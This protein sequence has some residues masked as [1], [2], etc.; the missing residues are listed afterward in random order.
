MLKSVW[1]SCVP[2]MH[3]TSSCSEPGSQWHGYSALGRSVRPEA[4]VD[5]DVVDLDARAVDGVDLVAQAV[6]ARERR[7]ADLG[8]R[9]SGISFTF[10][11][12]FTP[13]QSGWPQPEELAVD[14]A[15]H[16]AQTRPS[17]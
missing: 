6:A 1:H 13:W 9:N 14:E 8:T 5:L 17:P 10:D 12:S 15:A 2:I 16:S 11:G 7:G 4:L 3:S